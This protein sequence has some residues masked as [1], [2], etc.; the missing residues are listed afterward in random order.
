MMTSRERILAALEGRSVDHVPLTTWSFG[1]QPPPGLRW[2]TNGEERRYWYTQ[3]LEHI[4]TLPQAWTVEDDFRRVRAWRELGVDD[5]L[6]VSVPWS[7]APGVTWRDTQVPKGAMDADYPVM[8]RAYETP[9]G[10]LRH[11]VRRTGEYPGPGWVVQPDHV[12]LIEDYNIPRAV[13]HAVAAPEDVSI[14]KHLY[15]PP[16]A[17]ARGW[18]EA[19]MAVVQAFAARE[20]VAT[21]AWAGFGLD[22]VVW[23]AGTEG[24]VLLAMDAPDAF[25]RLMEAITETDRARVDL[26]AGCAGVDIVCARGWYSSTDFWSPTLFDQFIG[27][28]IREMA[29][30]AHRLGKRF[31]YVMTTGV[32][33]LGGRL[34]DAGVDLLYFVDPVQDRISVERARALLGGRMTLCGGTN[35][36]SLASG[37]AARIRGEVWR[38]LDALGPT[39]RFILHPVDALFPDTPWSG[40]EAMIGAWREH[41]GL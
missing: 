14:V 17:A 13:R 11:A 41:Q 30:A 35:A 34:A 31:G 32:E 8:V 10:L 4:H 7:V 15:R 12:P 3:R 26:A 22:A 20:G 5:I 24:A 29:A 19:R 18:F 16:D 39:N 2:A 36:L 21:Q 28:Y 38:A 33:A 9:A 25:A 23:F 1:L 40:V 27:P 6:D 37:D